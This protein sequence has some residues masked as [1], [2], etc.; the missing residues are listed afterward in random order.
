M[1]LRE[2][3][4]EDSRWMRLAQDSVQRRAMALAVLSVEACCRRARGMNWMKTTIYWYLV[5]ILLSYM[6]VLLLLEV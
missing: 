1:N 5:N 2:M 3:D 4:H 6:S